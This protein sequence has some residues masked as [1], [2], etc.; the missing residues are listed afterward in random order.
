MAMKEDSGRQDL[1]EHRA[2]V[3]PHWLTGLLRRLLVLGVIGLGVAALMPLFHPFWPLASVAEHFAFQILLGAVL[4]A[5]LA[6]VLH[7]W[8]WLVPILAVALIQI[9]IIHPYWP[10]S[11]A[12][13]SA[14]AG[15]RH[16]KVVSLNVWYRG[17]SY[18]AVRDYL[19]ASG[20]DVI[21]LAEVTP[22]WKAELAPLREIYPYGVD[23]IGSDQRC[24]QMLLSRHPFTRSGAGRI[25]GQLPVLAWGELAL[26]GQAT[27]AVAVTHLVWPLLPADTPV[28][29]GHPTA[30]LPAG[31]L[32]RLAQAEQALQL[33]AGLAQLPDDLVLMGDFNAAPWSRIQ[34]DLRTT[35]GLENEFAA[36]SWP[37][38]GPW[39]IRLPIDHILARGR[40]RIHAFA[41]G[42][43]IGSDHLPVEA[44][45][46]L[47]RP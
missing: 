17:D 15:E 43:E 14:A 32:P 11:V 27:L 18:Q 12:P 28:P 30:F 38:W 16:L 9:W 2:P 29:A 26:P 6:V 31:D 19:A 21:G 20:A 7:C 23:C 46:S 1:L 37:A 40:A 3:A 5:I 8:R 33:I 42:P 10:A 36:P 24:E 41:A 45:V 25:D 44:V 4:L 22:R 47:N 35:T 34:Q 13:K 39:P